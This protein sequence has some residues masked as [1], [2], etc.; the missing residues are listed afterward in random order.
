MFVCRRLCA[1]H[2]ILV[3]NDAKRRPTRFFSLRLLAIFVVCSRYRSFHDFESGVRMPKIVACLLLVRETY[4]MLKTRNQWLSYTN[5]FPHA[6]TKFQMN[7][8]STAIHFRSCWLFQDHSPTELS[9]M[10][11]ITAKAHTT[12]Q[13]MFKRRI[14]RAVEGSF[15][16]WACAI[17][18]R[19]LYEIEMIAVEWSFIR[20]SSA[21]WQLKT[22]RS[23]TGSFFWCWSIL[24]VV[25]VAWIYSHRASIQTH[26]N[27][28]S[29]S[30][31]FYTQ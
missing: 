12:I 3:P 11:R 18:P 15:G 20:C 22:M 27:V 31:G 10:V 21:V 25:I 2:T 9:L 23:G 1:C 6:T 19:S 13:P 14:V 17:T 29:H 8:A 5:Q 24:S 30:C 26:V 16:R 7:V 4:P 28:Q